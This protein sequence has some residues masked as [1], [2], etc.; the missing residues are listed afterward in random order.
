[1][2]FD[3][4]AEKKVPTSV[5]PAISLQQ[6]QS[7][8]VTANGSIANAS[9]TLQNFSSRP[10]AVDTGGIPGAIT[11]I[12][13]K[14]DDT[15]KQI[16]GMNQQLGSLAKASTEGSAKQAEALNKQ[17]DALNFQ[18]N[19]LKNEVAALNEESTRMGSYLQV[20][21]RAT[22]RG[23]STLTLGEGAHQS[24]VLPVVDSGTGA[25]TSKTLDFFVS[26]VDTNQ[27]TVTLHVRSESAPE[28][29]ITLQEG[30]S[31]EVKVLPHY[32]IALDSAVRHWVFSKTV[33]ITVTPEIA[34][35]LLGEAPP[36]PEGNTASL[37]AH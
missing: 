33:E 2:A 35:I 4:S 3:F 10:I 37:S 24:V 21:A 27:R 34:P 26:S 1:V 6:I 19:Q 11:S 12:S 8:L 7:Q 17:V 9:A 31:Q 15:S 32:H 23:V 20:V 25:I 30:I 14:L 16:D 29:K 28:E 18:A 36:Q 5:D 22:Q 13:A